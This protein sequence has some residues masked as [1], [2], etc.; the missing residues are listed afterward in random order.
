MNRGETRFRFELAERLGRTEAEILEMDQ[1]EYIQW[2]VLAEIRQ[3]EELAPDGQV[4]VEAPRKLITDRA[5]I[6]EWFRM[7]T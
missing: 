5:K 3:E 6:A 7:N 4:S 1:K 2:K